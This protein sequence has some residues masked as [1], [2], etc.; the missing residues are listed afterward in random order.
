[1]SCCFVFV[2][3]AV[4]NSPVKYRNRR[5]ISRLSSGVVTAFNCGDSLFNCGSHCRPLAGVVLATNFRLSGA[6]LCLGCICHVRCS[7]FIYPLRVNIYEYLS[8][9]PFFSTTLSLSFDQQLKSLVF[10]LQGLEN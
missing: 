2:N 7:F 4:S 5:L 10:Q 9:G 6:F 3:D 8:V 1:M